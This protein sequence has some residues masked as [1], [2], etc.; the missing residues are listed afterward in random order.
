MKKS[1]VMSIVLMVS[2]SF[3]FAAVS[4]AQDKDG[5]SIF[6]YKKELSITDK[7]ET[8]LRSILS[9]L[10]NYI[11]AKTKELNDQRTELSKMIVDKASLSMIK[12]KL[13]SIARIQADATYEDIASVRAIEKELTMEQMSKWRAIQEDFMKKQQEA[14]AAAAKAKEVAEQPKVEAKAAVTVPGQ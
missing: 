14:Q 7:Q 10:Q 1:I 13:Q 12:S 2:L 11:T 4:L 8:N 6:K 5:D 3:M 9:K